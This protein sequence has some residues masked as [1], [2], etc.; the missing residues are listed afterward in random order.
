MNDQQAKGTLVKVRGTL[1][2]FLGRL[3]GNRR[4]DAKG[5]AHQA[6]GTMRHGI[7]DIQQA[8]EHKPEPDTTT[9]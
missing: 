1:E 5:V 4:Q 7:G 9:P 6:E 2:S 3:T 8:V